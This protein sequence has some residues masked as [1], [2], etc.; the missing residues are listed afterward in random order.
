VLGRTGT[1][2][3][4]PGT[5]GADTGT[6]TGGAFMLLSGGM[7]AFMALRYGRRRRSV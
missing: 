2:P 7:F 4:P 1:P 3:Q 6:I 5:T